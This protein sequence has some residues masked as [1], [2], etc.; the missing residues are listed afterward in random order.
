[1]IFINSALPLIVL[2]FTGHCRL[3]NEDDAFVFS[4]IEFQP[5][6]VTIQ[7]SD[8]KHISV[9]FR[10]VTLNHNMT[11]FPHDVLPFIVYNLLSVCVF[12]VLLMHL[13]LP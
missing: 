13:F 5:S 2:I 3:L 8:V 12:Y 7:L 10:Y 1:M 9:L 11:C 4:D 6:S